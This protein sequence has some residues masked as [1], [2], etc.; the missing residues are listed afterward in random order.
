MSRKSIISRKITP[1]NKVNI[2]QFLYNRHKDT[3]T[4]EVAGGL[5]NRHTE[6][7]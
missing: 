1:N 6:A 3:H 4:P 7:I 5:T 2:L